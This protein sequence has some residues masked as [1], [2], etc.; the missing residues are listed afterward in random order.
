MIVR[1]LD[2]DCAEMKEL[3]IPV[4]NLN[5]DCIDSGIQI[6]DQVVVYPCKE[7][8]ILNPFSDNPNIVCVC[9]FAKKEIKIP[10]PSVYF[11]NGL[12]LSPSS[13]FSSPK[14]ESFSLNDNQGSGKFSSPGQ[15]MA[16]K[17]PS[18]TLEPMSPMKFQ[19]SQVDEALDSSYAGNSAQ[20]YSAA[21]I[22]PAQE[23]EEEYYDGRD[24]GEVFENEYEDEVVH[25]AESSKDFYSNVYAKYGIKP[26]RKQQGTS[27]HQCKNARGL[28]LLAFCTNAVKKRNAFGNRRCR[29]KYCSTCLK[30]FYEET[31]ENS[32]NP[33]WQCPSC[34]GIC[35]CAAC[36]RGA[37]NNPKKDSYEEDVQMPVTAEV[38]PYSYAEIQ[39]KE[40]QPYA[41]MQE[42]V[43]RFTNIEP[44]VS[45]KKKPFSKLVIPPVEYSLNPSFLQNP[46][47]FQFNNNSNDSS[48]FSVPFTSQMP[49]NGKLFNFAPTKTSPPQHQIEQMA[50]E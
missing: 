27:C 43:Q 17:F 19:N 49:M 31:I 13:A 40:S 11:N 44:H 33:D 1:Y 10:S 7:T 2:L 36:C 9:Q 23:I 6:S 18:I 46:H 25:N 16:T 35:T 21:T 45:P 12:K 28:H 32:K 4:N 39:K 30:K 5:D 41:I 14:N 15:S 48:V 29:K 3:I 8:I 22:Y 34:K 42:H 37:A 26:K 38:D 47:T 20:V 50:H 24:D